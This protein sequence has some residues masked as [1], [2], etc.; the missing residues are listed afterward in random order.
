VKLVELAGCRCD[1]FVKQNKA[2]HEVLLAEA[3]V[4]AIEDRFSAPAVAVDS[5]RADDPPLL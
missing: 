3:G 1:V 5:G 4:E 2:S